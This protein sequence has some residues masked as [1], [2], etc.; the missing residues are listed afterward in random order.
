MGKII[1]D[2]SISLDGF[3][4]ATGMTVDEGLG[5]G[6]EVLHDWYLAGEEIRERPVVEYYDVSAFIA[7]RRTY[8]NSIKWWG[9]EGHA[10]G[11][12]VIVSHSVPEYVPGNGAYIFVDTIAA[13]LDAARMGAGGKDVRVMGGN[14]AGQ[15]LQTGLLDEIAIHLTPV[16][17]GRGL[18]LFGEGALEL[19]S[20]VKLRQIE[21][22]STGAAMH[23]FYQVN[24]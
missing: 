21:V 3:I 9:A 17:F 11:P 1:Y 4:A 15:F 14:L 6:G 13:A 2:V 10:A 12:T 19:G 8:D 23:L 7:G 16:L 24:K 22:I 18:P 5:V 20:H